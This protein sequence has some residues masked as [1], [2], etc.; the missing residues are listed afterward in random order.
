MLNILRPDKPMAY[1]PKRPPLDPCPIEEV[2]AVI[3]GKWKARMML[4]LAQAPTPL[5]GLRAHLPDA[6]KPVL[7]RQ[8]KELEADGLIASEALPRGAARIRQYR[9]SAEGQS[10]VACLAQLLPWGLARLAARGEQWVP[11]PGTV[12]PLAPGEVGR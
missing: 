11:P 6:A 9:L 12:I 2:F 3:G 1:S 7:L 8:L 10:L 4:I 5:A